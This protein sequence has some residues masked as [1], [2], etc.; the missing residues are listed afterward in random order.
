MFKY[1]WLKRT[2]FRR[3]FG[4]KMLSLF[5]DVVQVKKRSFSAIHIQKG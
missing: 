4:D 2:V 5:K 3:D 1:K